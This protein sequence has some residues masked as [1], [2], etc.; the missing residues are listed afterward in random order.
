MKLDDLSKAFCAGTMFGAGTLGLVLGIQRI[1]KI[2]KCERSV[3]LA[4]QRLYEEL[5]EIIKEKDS[6]ND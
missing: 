2:A 3:K 4:T 1:I 6:L 5:S